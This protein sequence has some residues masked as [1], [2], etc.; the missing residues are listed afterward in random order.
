[1]AILNPEIIQFANGNTD[2]YLAAQDNFAAPTPEKS[3]LL[4]K[5]YFAEVERKANVA[6]AG[7][8]TEAWIS[9]PSVRWAAMSVLEATVEAI[10]PSVLTPAFSVFM[11]LRP[12]G[13]GDILKIKI[14]PNTLY[15]VSKGGKGDRSVFRQKK[16]AGDVILTPQEHIVTVDVSMYRVLA[17]KDD[18]GEMVRLV[19]LAVE[20]DMYAEAI[21]AL[22]TGLGSLTVGGAYSKSGAFDMATLLQ[23]CEQVQVYNSGV[24]PIICGSAVALMN[25]IPDSA[26][27][28]RGNFDA[29]GGG[30]NLIKTVFGYDVMRLENAAA[31]GGGLVLPTNKIFVVSPAQDKLVKMAVSNSLSNSNQF[32]DNADIT[33]NF[34]YRKNYDAVYASAAKAGIYTVTDQ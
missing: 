34:T 12:V 3:E 13:A 2:F 20:Q 22:L 14:K 31:A 27:G 19:V 6:R 25:V 9:H 21:N 30:I 15:T 1:M 26:N 24:R 17:G 8:S 28:Y 4:N 23:M 33:Q 5:A 10:L 32:Y 29:N 18:I 7:I 16:Y 11:D